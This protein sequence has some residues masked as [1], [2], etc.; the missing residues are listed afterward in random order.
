MS[1]T[2]K[3]LYDLAL[4]AQ[5]AEEI[6]RIA[7]G[8]G[9]PLADGEAA[10]LFDRLHGERMGEIADEELD[11]VA[12]GGCKGTRT[13]R[14]GVDK[15]GHGFCQCFSTCEFYKAHDDDPNVGECGNPGFT[16]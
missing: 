14:P 8:A 6:A 13:V 9:I 5:S 3:R 12:G 10:R 16:P 15:C 2:T 11:S 4:D 7:E 1:E